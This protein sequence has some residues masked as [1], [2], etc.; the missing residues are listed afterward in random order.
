MN[1]LP[2]PVVLALFAAA[3]FAA[4]EVPANPAAAPAPTL[5]AP[6]LE[7]TSWLLAAY[8]VGDALVEVTAGGPP[9][10]FQLAGGR[11]AGSPGCNRLGGAY[12]LDGDRLSFD[13]NLASTMMACPEP[14]MQQEQAV[15]AAL[16]KV[17]AYRLDGELLELTDAAGQPLLRFVRLKPTPLV[18]QVWQLQDYNNGKKAMVSVR[19]GTEI[20]LEFR[21]DGTLGGSDGCN[22]YMSGYTLE[23]ETLTFGPVATTRMACKGPQGAVEQARA[24]AAALGIVRG[25]RIDGGELT[26][27][28]GEGKAAVRLRVEAPAP[29]VVPAPTQ[30]SEPV[31][32]STPEQP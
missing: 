27:L 25:Y 28:D 13:A 16:V 30:S 4:A 17:A 7:D 15:G 21:D 2:V 19:N 24:Y 32:Q 22:R 14:L 31:V 26:L 20:T 5:S 29:V 8:R 3:L 18:G 1:H 6:T 9:A 12:T 11:I 23:G 10:R